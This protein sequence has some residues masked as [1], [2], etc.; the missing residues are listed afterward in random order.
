MQDQ[1]LFEEIA[2]I[3]QHIRQNEQ[4]MALKRRSE[5]YMV[6]RS[7]TKVILIIG[8]IGVL[9]VGGFLL[10]IGRDFTHSRRLRKSLEDERIK[11]MN[12][13]GLK[14]NFWQI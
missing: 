3:I 12:W 7:A 13:P 11:R 4:A 1:R 2:T 9:L 8:S 6:V 5:S 14:R 10:I